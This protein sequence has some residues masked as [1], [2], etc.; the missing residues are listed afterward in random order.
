MFKYKFF[1]GISFLAIDTSISI[2][3]TIKY[4]KDN[5]VYNLLFNDAL[6][7]SVSTIKPFISLKEIKKLWIVMDKFSLNGLENFQNLDFLYCSFSL[8]KE[9]DISILDKLEHL[10]IPWSKELNLN[11]LE[12]LKNLT[13][14]NVKGKLDGLSSL[15]QLQ[16]LTI[17]KSNFQNLDFIR[18]LKRLEYLDLAYAS[19]LSNIRVLTE[20]ANSLTE[21]RIDSC[22]K[23]NYE[24]VLGNLVKLEKIILSKS[25]DLAD[26]NFVK[27]MPRL[28]FFSFV[29][30]K[31]INGDMSSLEGI[32][33]L[34]F[35]DKKHYTH[36]EIDGKL[37]LK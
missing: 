26:I 28:K 3:E 11:K 33:Y 13:L 20:I 17:N 10:I 31:V 18:N 23:I 6:G 9:I 21:L 32:E 16:K 5:K 4:I 14:S 2:E 19:K 27:F 37:V 8:P 1:F 25:S 30:T 29:K 34:G 7:C 12:N 35:F 15:K 36:K 24:G 22:K